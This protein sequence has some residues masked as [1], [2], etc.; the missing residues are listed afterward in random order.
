MSG[1]TS[2]PNLETL[3]AALAAPASATPASTSTALLD[4][5]DYWEEVRNYYAAVRERPARPPPPTSTSTRSPAASTRNL[6][7]QAESVGV[8][9]RCPE[10]KRMYARGQRAARR[11]RQGDALLEGG[12]RPGAVHAHQQPHARGRA[13]AR[14]ASCTFPESV[15][16][17]FAGEIGQPPGGFPEPLAE[18]VLKGRKPFTG[19]PG[20]S[21]PPVD[22]DATQRERRAEDRPRRQRP[23]RARRT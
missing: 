12:G 16:G 20:D 9:D 1:L 5:T 10:L 14:H 4:F 3:V 11:H 21:L 15:I 19:R 13:R 8:G 17:Y 23:G 2:Q 22:F 6:R 7:P 18:V